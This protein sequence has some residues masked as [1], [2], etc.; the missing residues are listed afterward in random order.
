M[1]D[2]VKYHALLV[3][4]GDERFFGLVLVRTLEFYGQT[5]AVE[6][7]TLILFRLA[8]VHTV[9]IGFDSKAAAW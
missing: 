2:N 9:R 8:G 6:P 5:L 1:L 7:A 3:D 4:V